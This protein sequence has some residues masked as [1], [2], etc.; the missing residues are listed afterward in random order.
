MGKLVN[1]NSGDCSTLTLQR[2]FLKIWAHFRR[3]APETGLSACIFCRLRRQKDTA[4]IPCACQNPASLPDF[5]IGVCLWQTP[6]IRLR[7]I[8]METAASMPRTVVKNFI[9]VYHK[10][11][12]VKE[13]K[14]EDLFNFFP[15]LAL[16]ASRGQ[17]PPLH[18]KLI[19]LFDFTVKF[20]KYVFSV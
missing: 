1:R 15:V 11:E 4:S 17:T 20:P 19:R 5:G 7:R 2:F 12:K 14:N 13:V 9:A 6:S 3:F 8:A 18:S 16:N 10:V